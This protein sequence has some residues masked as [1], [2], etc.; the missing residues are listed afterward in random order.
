M[1]H[2]YTYN[3]ERPIRARQ[4]V[5]QRDRRLYAINFA[6]PQ[7]AFTAHRAAFEQL[8]ASWSWD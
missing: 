6:A 3:K 8:L 4:I 1:A 5:C 2:E 7:Q